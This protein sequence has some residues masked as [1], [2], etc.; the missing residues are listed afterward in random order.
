MHKLKEDE[1]ARYYDEVKIIDGWDA[2]YEFPPNGQVSLFMNDHMKDGWYLSDY[3]S[4]ITT[5][6]LR[7]TD[8]RVFRCLFPSW[9][10]SPRKGDDGSHI[11]CDSSPK[12]FT[13]WLDELCKTTSEEIVFINAWNEWGETATLEPSMEVG[14]GNLEALQNLPVKPDMSRHI[15]ELEGVRCHWVGDKEYRK[16]NLNQAVKMWEKGVGV[17]NKQCYINLS[18]LGRT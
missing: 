6:L 3:K 10:N 16:G 8:K 1:G 12:L 13:Y 5:S 14:Y 18:N 17:G 7:Q 11:Y 9:D 2:A 15:K 4:A